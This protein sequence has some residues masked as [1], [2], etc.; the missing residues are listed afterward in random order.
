MGDDGPSRRPDAGPATFFL[1]GDPAADALLA[2]D[3]LAVVIGMLL[4][5]QV[6]ITWA[7]RAPASLRDRW[8]GPWTVDALAAAPED[9]LV[10]LFCA[11]PALHRFPVTM[12]RRVH[13]LCGALVDRHGGRVE[14]LWADDADAATVIGRLRALPGFGDEKS[15]IYLALLAKRYA[16]TP[17]GWREACAPFG[18]DEPRTVADIDSP[19]ALARV[20]A[21]KKAQRAAGRSKADG[22]PAR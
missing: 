6:P 9:R 17:A 22:P 20:Q 12:A 13:A 11:K 7:F 19:D 10:E 5:Q 21:W 14:S 4:D 16:V 8:D 15:R 3:H 2:R 18:D 1:T